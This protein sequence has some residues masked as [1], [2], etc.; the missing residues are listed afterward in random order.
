[1]IKLFEMFAGYGG[2]SFALKKA[3]IPFECVG[4]S[5]IDKN[6]IKIYELNHLNI[7]NYGDCVKIDTKDLPD[8]NLLTGGFPCQD[9]SLAGKRDL[10]QGRTNLYTEILRIAAD[11]KPTWILLEN[12]K[13]LI[14]MQV[15]GR[16]LIEKIVTDFK[17]IGYGIQWNV[18]NSKD[19]GIPQSRAR[20]WII[21]KYGGLEF[22]EVQW[23][24]KKKLD[25]FI[26]DILEKEVDSKYNLS[27]TQVKFITDAMRQKKKYTQIN[28]DISLT[29]KERQFSNWN[30]DFIQYDPN[31]AGHN[32]QQNR[33]YFSEGVSPCLSGASKVSGDCTPKIIC[34]VHPSGSGINGNVYSSE[35]EAPNLTTNKGEGIKIFAMRGRE[36]NGNVTQQVEVNSEGIVNSL[37]SVQK[38]NYIMHNLQPRHGKGQGGKGHIYKENA[39]AYCVDTGNAQALSLGMVFRKLT[40]REC[41][42]LMGFMNDEIIFGDLSNSALYK[43]AGNGWEINVVSLIFKEI[44]KNDNIY[45]TQRI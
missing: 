30:G 6:A 41:F 40:P 7:K 5:E 14:S 27:G 4:Y 28:G 10:S 1:M 20:V 19:Y 26:K 16:P 32:S 35:N 44:Y 37:T 11:K 13:G 34:N 21:G 43:L 2:A 33:A 24:K 45:K 9:V 23:P 15:N 17:K 12:V 38:D 39:E 8:F 29:Q 25:I 31:S 18:L 22:N 36:Q 42:R 3:G